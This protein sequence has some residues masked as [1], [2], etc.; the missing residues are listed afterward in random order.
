MIR[1]ILNRSEIEQIDVTT[2]AS[3]LF[4]DNQLKPSDLNQPIILVEGSHWRSPG[5]KYLI[6]NKQDESRVRDALKSN[7]DLEVAI[8]SSTKAYLA[9]FIPRLFSRNKKCLYDP[10]NVY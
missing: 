10:G 2:S 4:N 7:S 3:G 8:I 9:N 1:K 6:Y 5:K